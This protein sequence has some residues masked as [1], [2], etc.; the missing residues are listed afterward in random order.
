[1]RK[2]L[3]LP[4]VAVIGGLIG[5]VVRSRFLVQAFEPDTGLAVR[6]V[7]VAYA[8]WAVA[9]ITVA[10]I[11]ALSLGKHRTFEKAY[12][13]AFGRGNM[14]QTSCNLAAAGLFL[15]AGFFNIEAFVSSPVN[16]FTMAREVSIVRPI[17]GVVCLGAAAGIWFVTQ[18]MKSFR[19]AKSVW[20][21]LPGFTSCLWVMANYQ[22]WAQD[23]NLEKY[24]FSLV[25]I[26]LSMVGCYCLPG[27][28]FGKGQV[29]LTLI[30]C[31][32]AAAFGIMVLGDGLPL[33]DTALIL[34]MVFYLGSMASI[35]LDND[36]RPEPPKPVDPT[37]C[38]GSCQG[39]TG[40]G[41]VPAPEGNE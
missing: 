16:A 7:P 13:S 12:T 10:A 24:L 29:P 2:A 6:G 41:P 22:T 19:Q 8:M 25:A 4:A 35:L 26:L 38:G 9:L 18:E 1:M 15:A 36:A 37:S 27:F 31:L 33:M 5:L 30:T 3:V 34:A 20:T 17:L 23:P 21:L 40:C 39:C 14:I 28:A 11:A 32:S